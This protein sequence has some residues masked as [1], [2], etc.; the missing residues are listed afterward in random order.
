[1]LAKWLPDDA[2]CFDVGAHGGLWTRALALAKP[3]GKVFAFEALPYYATVLRKTIGLVGPKNISIV[4]AAVSESS[5][6]VCMIDKS[7]MGQRLTGKSHV[8]NGR[9]V[10]PNSVGV[11]AITLDEFWASRGKPDVA[12]V[13]CDVEGF[14]LFVLKG[15]TNLIDTCRPLFY[16]ELN[17]EWCERYGYRP[18]DIFDFFAGRGYSPAYIARNGCLERVSI[19]DHLNRDVLFVPERLANAIQFSVA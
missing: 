10:I 6:T 18:S 5:G 15:A 11:N 14:E 17:H 9:E 13:K 16:N 4:N 8:S 19:E 12:F 3:H 7:P 1:M 2:V